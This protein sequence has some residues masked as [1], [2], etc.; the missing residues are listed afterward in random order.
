MQEKQC[1]KMFA[2]G[3]CSKKIRSGK[4]V[5]T[6]QVRTFNSLIFLWFNNLFSANALISLQFKTTH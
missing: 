1:F 5:L 3:K 2:F 4:G 6:V